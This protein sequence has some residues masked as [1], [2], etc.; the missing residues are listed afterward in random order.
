MLLAVKFS[1]TERGK[2]R[3]EFRKTKVILYFNIGSSIWRW[4]F[5]KNSG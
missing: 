5:H 4:F 2:K 3:V 1:G